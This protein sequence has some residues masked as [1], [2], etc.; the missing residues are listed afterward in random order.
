MMLHARSVVL[1]VA[2]ALSA[3]TAFA[4]DASSTTPPPPGTDTPVNADYRAEP[5]W[6]PKPDPEKGLIVVFRESRFV[7]GGAAFKLFY[8]DNKFPKLKNGSFIFVY[9]PPGDYQLYS[10]KKKRRDA[11]LLQV[12]PGEVYYFEASIVMGMLKGSIDLLPTEPE[13]AK[14]RMAELKKP[15]ADGTPK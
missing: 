13:I 2:L 11:R 10:D 1:T 14:A 15:K 3:V 8:G 5:A 12:E 4:Q 6:M 9:L 7:G